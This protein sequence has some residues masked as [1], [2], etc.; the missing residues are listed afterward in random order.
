[1]AN[2]K[3]VIVALEQRVSEY[4]GLLKQI[5]EETRMIGKV[6]SGPVVEEGNSF[7]RVNLN[8]SEIFLVSASSEKL[9]PEQEVLCNKGCITRA[10]PKPLSIVKAPEPF[11]GIG[12]K[13]VGG[14]KSQ[15]RE[16]QRQVE[17]QLK[18]AKLY[19]EF[20]I[21]PSKGA[22]LYGPPGCGKTLISKVIA[23][24]IIGDG[25]AED[26]VYIK[27][28]ELL[29]RYV[30]ATEEQIRKI[31]NESRKRMKKTGVRS[32]IFIDEAESLLSRR[33]TGIS[34]DVNSTIV[35]QFLAE[36]D[37]FDENSPY[38][39]LSTNL[40]NSLDPAIVREGRIDLKLEIKRPTREDAK[41]I[42]AI[43]LEK[44][45]LGEKTDR[46]SEHGAE[47]L[48]DTGVPVSG[49][50]IKTISNLAAQEALFRY[51]ENGGVKGVTGTDLSIAIEKITSSQIQ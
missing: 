29:S 51:M 35:P 44:V 8:G 37:G 48:Y 9:E 40:P 20:G 7:Y 11:K 6:V 4:E 10:L 42:F 23:S 41:E 43:H 45:K 26:F 33:G 16:I 34:S 5:F 49:S 15:I 50:M 28:P 18:N 2:D 19:K 13:E 24:S 21:E 31:F 12:W 46:L 39:L 17:G 1:M 47:R 22:L 14:L 27:G 36:M 3:E 32:V 30:G 38:V 25:E